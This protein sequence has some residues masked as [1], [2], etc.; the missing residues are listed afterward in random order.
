M[1]NDARLPNSSYESKA[2][3]SSVRQ[4]C[5]KLKNYACKPIAELSYQIVQVTKNLIF[6]KQ[7]S[8]FYILLPTAKNSFKIYSKRERE[9]KQNNRIA[10]QNP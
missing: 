6:I 3:N 8:F 5:A 10:E 2:H 1:H 9:N 4:S 7:F